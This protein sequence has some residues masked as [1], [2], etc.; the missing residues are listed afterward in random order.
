MIELAADGARRCRGAGRGGVV[1]QLQS[2]FASCVGFAQLAQTPLPLL[3]THP[4]ALP[5]GHGRKEGTGA[6]SL[7]LAPAPWVP[8]PGT[9]SGGLVFWCAVA[10]V[11]AERSAWAQGLE[12]H[13]AVRAGYAEDICWVCGAVLSA[14]AKTRVC[15]CLGPCS[16]F[17]ALH[18]MLLIVL[19]QRPGAV[20]VS[21]SS[22]S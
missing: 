14:Q 9:W 12:V 4:P 6:S 10:T 20:F 18:Q 22:G 8:V 7:E 5:L 19:V 15:A 16:G 3:L 11:A 1:C 17:T 21:A 2:V 13:L